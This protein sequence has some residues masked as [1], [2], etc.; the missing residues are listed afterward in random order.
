VVLTIPKRLRLYFRYDRRLLADLARAA[1]RAITDVVR[2]S[3]GEDETLDGT[4]KCIADMVTPML[5]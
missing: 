3:T 5:L 4:H 1:A 2:V